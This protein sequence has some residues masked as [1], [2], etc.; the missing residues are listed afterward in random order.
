[1]NL[2][3][4]FRR[5]PIQKFLFNMLTGFRSSCFHFA[6]TVPF[7]N[8][9]FCLHF[10]TEIAIRANHV[11]EKT[12][13]IEYEQRRCHNNRVTA[14]NK[15]VLSFVAVVSQKSENVDSFQR[16]SGIFT[17]FY[18]FYQ[19]LQSYMLVKQAF[20][21]SFTQIGPSFRLWFRLKLLKIIRR[22]SNTTVTQLYFV[23]F[24]CIL[25]QILWIL[26]IFRSMN[27][28]L[29]LR[30]YKIGKFRSGSKR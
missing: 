9:F 11:T 6:V 7:K 25:N 20:V 10:W 1:M 21:L 26:F 18:I 24:M 19:A 14:V 16:K 5:L 27:K 8:N 23:T 28:P 2:I 4:K 30:G 3:V 22:S 12:R 17:S 15:P 13:E 29:V